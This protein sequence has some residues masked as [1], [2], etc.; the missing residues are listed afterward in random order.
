MDRVDMSENKNGREVNRG[1]FKVM[2]NP[3]IEEVLAAKPK[4]FLLLFQI[5]FRA[6]RTA[7]FNRYNLNPGEAFIGDLKTIGLTDGEYRGAKN[8][9]E[10]HGFATFK[11]TNK[12]TIATLINSRVFDINVEPTN[13]QT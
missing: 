3:E 6:Q 4:A 1:W 7:T 13:E 5:A 10:K 8:F 2:R 9:L 12:G 11:P